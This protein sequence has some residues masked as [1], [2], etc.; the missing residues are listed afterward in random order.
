MQ[1]LSPMFQA[2]LREAQF[3]KE[4]L[5]SGATQIRQANYAAKGV[6][7]QAF[8][9]LSTGLERIGKLCLMLDHFVDANGRFP[10]LKFLKLDIG[11]K[12]EVL[13]E[14]SQSVIQKRS[15]NLRFT[16]D[17]SDPIHQAILR[18]LHNFAE[19]DRYSNIDLLV[20]NSKSEDPI[21]LW[22]SQV[23]LALY[24]TRVT[25]RKKV[26]IA[27]RAAAGAHFMGQFALVLHTFE[28]GDEITDFE[29]ASFRTGMYQA[30]APHRQLYVLQVV[31][32][33]V[34]L[35]GKLEHIAQS[36]PGEDI[37]C[38]GE[39]FSLFCNDDAYIKTRKTWGKL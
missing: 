6:Y 11:H 24:Q 30:V 33:W 5:G 22:F 15:I 20:G 4:M 32:Y 13:Y 12:L 28:T 14:K 3:T 17:L 38:F 29:K 35:L 36:V 10:D 34:E 21:A 19:G 1:S 25:E 39:V 9:S 7:F 2:L 31:R 16:E 27:T 8:T 26:E 23:D 18:V 37:P